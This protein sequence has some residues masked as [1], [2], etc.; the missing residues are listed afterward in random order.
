MR[1]K[2]FFIMLCLMFLLGC[3]GKPETCPY[4]N[5]AEE[6]TGVTLIHNQNEY[7]EGIDESKFECIRELNADEI[8]FFMD[9]VCRLPTHRRSGGPLWGYGEYMAK[10]TYAN[11]DIEILG[12]LNI[13]YIPNG[14]APT[15]FGSY[16]FEG[17]GLRMLILE[18]V[19]IIDTENA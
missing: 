7:G 9:S 11:G 10:V 14:S 19:Q 18:Y 13:E 5:P 1:R 8:D 6:I 15:G 3:S 4:A 17:D 2:L 16:Y 12:T